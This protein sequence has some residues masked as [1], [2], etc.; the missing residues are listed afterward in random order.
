MGEP[1]V[2][3]YAGVAVVGVL[4]KQ[5]AACGVL[6]V[7]SIDINELQS[8]VIVLCCTAA[9]CQLSE[10]GKVVDAKGAWYPLVGEELV[11]AGECLLGTGRAVDAGCTCDY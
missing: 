3:I 11:R 5:Q 2:H 8:L 4:A 7:W 6:S 9:F 1:I 10:R